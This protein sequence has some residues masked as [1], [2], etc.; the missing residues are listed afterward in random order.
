MRTVGCCGHIER[1]AE[2]PAEL[3]PKALPR[4]VRPR[5]KRSFELATS[6]ITA[7]SFATLFVAR[8]RSL[9]GD[10]GSGSPPDASP[11]E[12]ITLTRRQIHCISCGLSLAVRGNGDSIHKGEAPGSANA[13][14]LARGPVCDKR[15][16]GWGTNRRGATPLAI[17]SPIRSLP[18]A[19]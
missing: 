3:T 18:S 16:C 10:G 4:S 15:L 17:L 5:T 1:L 11:I 13:L 7:V 14:H 19:A 9:T 6:F 12:T 2:Q 8:M